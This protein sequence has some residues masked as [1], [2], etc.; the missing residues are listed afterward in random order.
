MYKIKRTCKNCGSH[1]FKRSALSL[2]YWC[3]KCNTKH[4]K[5]VKKIKEVN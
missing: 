3:R 4:I 2:D 5:N 1:N